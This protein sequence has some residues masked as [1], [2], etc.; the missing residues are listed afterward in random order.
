MPDVLLIEPC[1]FEDFPIGGQLTFAGQVIA[2]FGRF[3][4]CVPS[5]KL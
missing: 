5:S 2:A 1:D 4:K 3:A